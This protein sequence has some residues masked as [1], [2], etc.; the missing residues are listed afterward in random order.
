MEVLLGTAERSIV[1]VDSEDR[2]TDQQLDSVLTSV[3]RMLAISP[4]GRYLAAFGEDGSVTVTDTTFERKL[5]EFDTRASSRPAQLLWCGEDAVVVAWP[6]RGVLVIG[7]S[8][9]YLS[10]VRSG[11]G[12][13]TVEP[14]DGDLEGGSEEPLHVVQE[15][16]GVRMLSAHSHTLLQRVPPSIQNIRSIGSTAPAATLVNAA[17]K[18]EAADADCDELLRTLLA[19][20]T[21]KEAVAE[22]IGA[23][24]HEWDTSA[25]QHLLRCASYGKSFDPDF[26]SA[27]FVEACKRL[28][29]LNALR[30]F[31]AG[32]PLTAH[33]FDTLTAPVVVDRLCARHAYRLALQ[34]CDYLGLAKDRVLVHWACAKVRGS[35]GQ[36]DEDIRD[37]IRR[38]LAG[39]A[40]VSY[41]DI[42]AAADSAGRRKLATMLLG[43]EPRLADQVPI[44]LKMR[45]GRLA[46][47]RAIASGDTDLVYL[48]LL[49]LQRQY[50]GTAATAA[51]GG[52]GDGVSAAES[53][54]E[55]GGPG[56]AAFLRVVQAYPAA[57]DLLAA[58]Y[59]DRQSDPGMLVRLLQACGRCS[60]AGHALL[61]NAALVSPRSGGATLERHLSLLQRAVNV[62]REGE[63]SA[64]AGVAGAAERSAC[65]FYRSAT[66][67]QAQLLL[68][69]GDLDRDVEGGDG[70]F[71]GLS[72]ADTVHRLVTAGEQKRAQ[73]LRDTF[74]MSDAAW[75]HVRIAA[76][77]E[78]RDWL[79]LQKLADERR[80]G[81]VVGFT[82]LVD[83]CLEHDAVV[84]ARK[85][86][87][88]IPEFTERFKA[89]V[90][91]GAIVEAAEAATK[92]RDAERLQS[93][94][95][96]ARSLPAAR[97]AIEEGLSLMGR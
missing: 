54:V 76:L 46:L 78:A 55:G 41:A 57:V 68:L 73:M 29:L 35:S 10:F 63:K 4:S 21:L 38:N 18:F 27:V 14:G 33:Q 90:A 66:E 74:R 49:H 40:G 56:Q 22:C 12:V 23:A 91:C 15:G 16:D 94:L 82:P 48:A 24:T 52:A 75:A 36:S 44:L 42:A 71:V 59:R 25:Q 1:T 92:A 32:L 70:S 30:A 37:R 69:Q 93:L 3:V 89:L 88:R 58:Y 47:E 80:G 84:E 19:E 45:E 8:G 61:A 64:P 95:P 7:P 34:V 85:Y 39:V 87:G 9:D 11:D 81:P 51:V 43:F 2:A 97:A 72:L 96:L 53:E 6:E 5:T 86:A 83:A 50:Q 79:A 65:A 31:G 60:D 20:D 28:R 17:A 62:F 26:D 67:E 13:A 77:A